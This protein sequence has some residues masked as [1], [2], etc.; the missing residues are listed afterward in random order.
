MH[1]AISY[2]AFSV[3]LSHQYACLTDASKAFDT[4][5]HYKMFEKLLD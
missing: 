1:T 3:L 4:I 5:D 2:N